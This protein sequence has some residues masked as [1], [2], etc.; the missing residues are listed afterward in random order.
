MEVSLEARL[1]LAR[2]AQ[3][4][5]SRKDIPYHLP[6]GPPLTAQG[7]A[8]AQA[9]AAFLKSVGV[10]KVYASPLERALHTAQVACDLLSMPGAS[11]QPIVSER[12]IEWQPDDT[13]GGVIQRCWPLI[14]SA[15]EESLT[16]GPVAL[17]SHGGPINVLLA[18]MGLSEG[19]I[20]AYKLQ[21]DHN[22]PIPTAGAWEVRRNG[23][24]WE[25]RFAF[26]PEND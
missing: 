15:A 2:H 19:E 7:L 16:I 8:E 9:L 26:K 20:E 3:P 22:N 21:F 18:A 5:W 25:P 4:D 1:Y 11:L 13:A 12:L 6:P 17:V 24:G 23:R 10:R 14:E